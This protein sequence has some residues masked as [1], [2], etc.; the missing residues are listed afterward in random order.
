MLINKNNTVG[1]HKYA[2]SLARMLG[3][4][5]IFTR[6]HLWHSGGLQLD[7]T[8]AHKKEVRLLKIRLDSTRSY[9]DNT[10]NLPDFQYLK[11]LTFDWVPMLQMYLI[12]VTFFGF[13]RN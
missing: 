3:T 4:I 11:I 13:L 5:T 6:L 8:L 7:D 9:S 10:F 1:L 2:N 12:H